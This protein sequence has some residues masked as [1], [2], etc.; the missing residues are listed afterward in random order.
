L[1]HWL[2]A[3]FWAT[4]ALNAPMLLV[5]MSSGMDTTFAMAYFAAYLLLL[6]A[7]EP[8]LSPGKAFLTGIVGGLAWTIRPD[9]MLFT[10]GV[11]LAWAIFFKDCC[12]PPSACCCSLGWRCAHLGRCCRSPFTPSR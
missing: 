9:L 7:F 1:R 3:F 12:L 8:Q 10:V 11:P 5:H 6:H 2:S 4:V